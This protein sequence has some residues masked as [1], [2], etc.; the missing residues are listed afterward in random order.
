MAEYNHVK[1]KDKK[2]SIYRFKE[3]GTDEDGFR[4]DDIYVKIHDGKLWAHYR[5]TSAN[6][7]F[8]AMSYQY[9]EESIFTVNWRKDIDPRTDVILYNHH[10]YDINRVD[11]YEGYKNDLRISAKFAASQRMESYPGMVDN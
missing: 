10:I 2:I 1:L 4:T 8:R 11:D 3:G 7:Y 5:Q 6:E 9:V